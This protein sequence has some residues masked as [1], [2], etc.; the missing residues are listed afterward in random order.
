M[1]D[2]PCLHQPGCSETYKTSPGSIAATSQENITSSSCTYYVEG[3]RGH[4]AVLNFTS[5]HGFPLPEYPPGEEEKENKQCR[6]LVQIMEIVGEGAERFLGNI[7]HA[8]PRV[9]HSNS[10]MVKMAFS[11]LPSHRSGFTLQY[12]FN[13]QGSA[14]QFQCREDGT[15]LPDVNL[16]CNGVTDCEQGSDERDCLPPQDPSLSS[17]GWAERNRSLLQVVIIVTFLVLAVGIVMACILLYHRVGHRMTP[18]D[19]DHR[20]L[21]SRSSSHIHNSEVSEVQFS[22]LKTSDLAADL[23]RPVIYICMVKMI[24]VRVYM[25][26]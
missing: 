7:C 24:T 25:M 13:K 3:D 11:W 19:P 1:S 15:C 14:C 6:P 21:T 9:F 8:K 20:H 5:F 4:Y 22:A 16:V 26:W 18:T 12:K 17:T 23:V 10:H 2:M